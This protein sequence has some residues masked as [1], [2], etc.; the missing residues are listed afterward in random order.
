MVGSN[1]TRIHF[2][3]LKR[4]AGLTNT[5]AYLGIFVNCG[6]KMSYNVGPLALSSNIRLV[7]KG[8]SMQALCISFKI[9]YD[10]YRVLLAEPGNPYLRGWPSIV[11]LIVL[12]SI[13]SAAFYISNN[14]Y[15]F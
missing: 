4:L 14:V 1:L 15:F 10:S 7:R 5:L 8:L 13:L 9:I 2:T 11:Y 6:R 3:R 12:T